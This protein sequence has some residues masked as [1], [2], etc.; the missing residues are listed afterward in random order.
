MNIDGEP[1]FD[2]VIATKRV[3]AFVLQAGLFWNNRAAGVYGYIAENGL[4]YHHSC[5]SAGE[6]FF[7][8]LESIGVLLQ[9]KGGHRLAI[10]PDAI[11]GY[12]A[13]L[14]DQG[15][16]IDIF[17]DALVCIGGESC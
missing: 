11:L 2:L 12:A 13:Y 15:R 14:V 8:F 16:S 3:A 17:I 5:M 1:D 6:D 9:E 7:E 4:F 10:R